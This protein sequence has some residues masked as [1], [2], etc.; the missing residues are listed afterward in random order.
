[1]PVPQVLNWLLD[2]LGQNISELA[3]GLAGKVNAAEKSINVGVEQE[4][5][6]RVLESWANGV[7][8]RVGNIDLYFSNIEALTFNGAF[9][10]DTDLNFE[11]QFQSTLNFIQHKK[12]SAELLR[13]QIPM[14]Q[15]NRIEDILNGQADEEEKNDLLN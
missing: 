13:E 5:I 11:E 3:Q 15:A 10:L 1:M 4:S 12:L 7:V 2:L 8:P 14:S 6:Q 9:K